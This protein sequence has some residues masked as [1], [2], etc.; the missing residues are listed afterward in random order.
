MFADPQSVTISGTATSLPRVKDQGNGTLYSNAEKTVTLSVSHEVKK[1]NRSQIRLAQT[2]TA[3]DPFATGVN[4]EYSMSAYLVI[5]RPVYGFSA[6]EQ[7]DLVAA[8][9]AYLTANTNANTIKFVGG[10]A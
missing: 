6:A 1:R 7:K 5:D 9:A 2:K 4:R 3:P 10:E 8:L